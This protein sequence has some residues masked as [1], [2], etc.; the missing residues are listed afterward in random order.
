M[1]KKINLNPTNMQDITK[2]S[3]IK[4]SDTK[5]KKDSLSLLICITSITFFFTHPIKKEQDPYDWKKGNYENK[6]IKYCLDPPRYYV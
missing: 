1:S 3:K 5:L 4:S 2:L 6:E